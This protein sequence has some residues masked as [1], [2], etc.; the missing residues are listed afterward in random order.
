MKLNRC[1]IALC[2]LLALSCC[3]ACNNS[4]ATS[5]GQGIQVNLSGSFSTIEAGGAPVTLTATVS[6]ESINNGVT[7]TLSIA[8]TDCSPGC[9]TLKAGANS[10][11]SYTAVYTPPATPPINSTASISVRSKTDQQKVFVFNFQITPPITVGI[12][13]KFGSQT[14]GGGAVDIQ[15]TITNDVTNAGVAWTLTS[16]GPSGSDCSPACGSL[17]FGPAPSLT[18]HYTPPSVPPSGAN[19]SPTIAAASVVDSTK[20]DNFSFAIGAPPI[21]VSI[22]NKFNTVPAGASA[23]TVSATITND[24]TNAGL[25]W[26]LTAGGADCQP[27]CGTLTPAASPSLSASYT[28]PATAPAGAAASPT[29]TATSVADPTKSDSFSFNIIAANSVFK[30]SYAFLLRGYDSAGAPTAMTGSILTD[31]NGNITRGDLDFNDKGTVTSISGSLSGSYTIDTSF[32]SIPRLTINITAASSTLTFRCS[33][34]ADGTRGT[35]IQLDGSLAVNAGV[36]L[37]QDQTALTA[38]NPAGS[39]AFGLD[40]DAGSSGGISGRIVEA[41]QFILG[42][43]G[44]S[45]TGGFADAGQSGNGPIFGGL[46]GP[47]A[48]SADVATAPDSF[49]RGTLTLTINGNSNQYAYYIVDGK[50]LNLLEIDSGGTLQTLQAG[51]AQIQQ[52]M[53]SNSINGTGIVALAGSYT[54]SS[55]GT[56]VLAPKVLIGQLIVSG[57]TSTSGT[58]DSNRNGFVGLRQPDNGLIPVAQVPST[59]F[60]PTTGR[61]LIAHSP[62]TASFVDRVAVYLYAPETGYLADVSV[63][64]LNFALSGSLTPQLA[65]PFSPQSLSGNLIAREGPAS[66]LPSATISAYNADLALNL[67]PAS[68]TYTTEVDLTTSNVS[69]GANG[70]VHDVT[71]S[72]QTYQIDDTALGAGH[73]SI[74]GALVGDPNAFQTDLATFYIIDQN[75]FVAIGFGQTGQGGPPSQ[76]LFFDPQ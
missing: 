4:S 62:A 29:I 63:G 37:K 55:S 1:L 14:A 21:S 39:Y 13:P 30:G 67:D 25:S 61:C 20:S 41:G 64:S 7:W 5:Q 43:G 72:S 2:S 22:A 36:L 12:A 40:S 34:S 47:A 27:T 45:V 46:N 48:I 65:G 56:P 18:A 69:I 75:K 17:T 19:A 35:I 32:N 73:L 33:L 3:E 44:T 50:Q 57:G 6:G 52:T 54:D 76:I 71:L 60:D 28:P 10:G 26:A 16:G 58:F 59:A 31:G 24:F 38:A 68:S 15:A 53:D 49:G 51:T 70:Q 74:V 11:S 9:G 8:N 66:S 23:L 42:S